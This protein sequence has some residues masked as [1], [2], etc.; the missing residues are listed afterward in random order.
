LIEALTYRLS[1]HTTAD[2][3][4]RYRKSQEVKDAWALEPLL[5]I[6]AFLMNAG[7]WDAA[8]EQALL[9]ECTLDVDAAVGEYLGRAKPSTD[10]MFEHLFAALPAHLHEQRRVARKY[11]SKPSSH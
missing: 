3:A 5:R 11:G 1:D 7:L 10:A 2:D 6:R 9:E 4:S 8:K